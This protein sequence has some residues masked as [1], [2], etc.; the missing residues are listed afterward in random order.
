MD[1]RRGRGRGGRGG[2]FGI[3]IEGGRKAG[4]GIMMVF[5]FLK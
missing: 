1:L 2:G 3:G 4:G 5:P